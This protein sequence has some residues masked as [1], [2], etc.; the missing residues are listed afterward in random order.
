ME[1]FIEAPE[2]RTDELVE[3]TLSHDVKLE[4]LLLE[5]ICAVL[6]NC[7][8][9]T[10]C[11]CLCFVIFAYTS[12]SREDKHLSSRLPL[13]HD[14]LRDTADKF[15]DDKEVPRGGG[16]GARRLDLFFNDKVCS[17]LLLQTTSVE[18]VAQNL[19]FVFATT[20]VD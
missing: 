9:S 3:A 4:L 18:L 8:F 19:L 10:A 2:E 17:L 11:E 14:V 16:V 5:R 1:F 15:L 7:P 12:S 13:L 6:G 20:C